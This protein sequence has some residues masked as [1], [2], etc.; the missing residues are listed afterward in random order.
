[1]S[2]F[3]WVARLRFSLAEDSL[4]SVTHV[5]INSLLNYCSALYIENA[6]E[7]TTK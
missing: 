2:S 4:V 1:M 6:L 3:S 7:T 5:L